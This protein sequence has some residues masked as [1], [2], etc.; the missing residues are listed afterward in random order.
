MSGYT[1]L[2][3]PLLSFLLTSFPLSHLYSQHAWG[4]QSDI[5]DP[6]GANGAS[7]WLNYDQN[8]HRVFTAVGFNELPDFLNNQRDNFQE[9]RD[10]FLQLGYGYKTGMKKR[11]IL[12]AQVMYKDMTI[13]AKANSSEEDLQA[14]RFCPIMIYEWRFLKALPNIS[15]SPWASYRFDVLRRTAEFSS[16]NLSYQTSFANFA[17]GFNLGYTF[18][19]KNKKT[20]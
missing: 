5:L 11:F 2:F 8:R 10:F 1:K 4:I 20:R 18:L 17:M 16:P 3:I 19:V 15:L 14:L 12:G 7:L 6:L 13:S 9:K